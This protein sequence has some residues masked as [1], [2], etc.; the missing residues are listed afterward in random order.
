[1]LGDILN[2]GDNVEDQEDYGFTGSFFK[3]PPTVIYDYTKKKCL[4]MQ[5]ENLRTHRNIEN[6]G[7]KSDEGY[8]IDMI[9]DRESDRG[10][11][12]GKTRKKH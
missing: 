9:G 3:I 4:N 1:M 11:Q 10:Y 12:V 5:L 7:K 2:A 6:N 8:Q